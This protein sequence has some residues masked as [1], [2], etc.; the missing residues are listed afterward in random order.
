[1][2]VGYY[3]NS[4]L[5]YRTVVEKWNGARWAL[6]SQVNGGV[7]GFLYSI[8]CSGANSCI[9][10]GQR[11]SSN[12]AMALAERWNGSRLSVVRM[13]SPGTNGVLNGVACTSAVNCTAV[14]NDTGSA[15]VSVT[16]S[17][18]WNGSAWSVHPTPNG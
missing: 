11:S 10:V 2:A 18:H 16:L 13:P 12:G 3:Q 6:V 9:A 1:M 17:E 4:A 14:G 15:G 5:L 7:S 8:A